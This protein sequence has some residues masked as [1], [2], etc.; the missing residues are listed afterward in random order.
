MGPFI[1]TDAGLFVPEYEPEP[2]PL[3]PL[4]VNPALGV[5]LIETLEPLL[6]QP[7]AGPT[8]PPDPAFIVRKY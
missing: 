8:A 3:Q 1:V 2:V 7:L 4:K 6:T 5:A